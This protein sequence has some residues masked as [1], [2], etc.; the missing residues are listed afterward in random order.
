MGTGLTILLIVCA[1]GCIST[2]IIGAIKNNAFCSLLSKIF[3]VG[4]IVS[5]LGS[6]IK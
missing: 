2:F 1:V 6:V 5:L 4:V 3:L